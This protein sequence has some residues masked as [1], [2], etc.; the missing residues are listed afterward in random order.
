MNPRTRLHIENGK[1]ILITIEDLMSRLSVGRATAVEIAEDCKAVVKYGRVVRYN[2]E[3]IKE[4]IR[5]IS[6]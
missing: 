3:M 1:E 5:E 2:V 6:A 4:Y